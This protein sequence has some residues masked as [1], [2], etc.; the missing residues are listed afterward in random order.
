MVVMA[1]ELL[2]LKG[3]RVMMASLDTLD[4]RELLVRQEPRA[5]QDPEET[6]ASVVSQVNLVDLVRREKLASLDLMAR[7]DPEDRVL[8]NVTWSRR[9]V[10]TALV[11]TVPKSAHSTPLSWPS[12]W[13]LLRA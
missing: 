7:K 13:T 4:L 11:A 12:P 10:T 9:F 6:V 5:G 2:D 3:K 1:L 8:C